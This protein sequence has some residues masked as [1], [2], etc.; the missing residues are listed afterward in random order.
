MEKVSRF[1]E[2]HPD[3]L[4]RSQIEESVVGKAQ[5]VRTAIDTLVAEGFATEFSGPRNARLVRLERA[6]RETEEAA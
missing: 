5:Y 6:F 3:P 4:P 2:V 1:L